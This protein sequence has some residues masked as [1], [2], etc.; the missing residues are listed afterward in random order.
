M[1]VKLSVRT[2]FLLRIA[3]L[4]VLREIRMRRGRRTIV[5]VCLLIGGLA[6]GFIG[7]VSEEA[8]AY[9][10]HGQI[11]ILSD[12]D[13]TPA[14]GVISGNGTEIDPY[15]IA[16][17]EIDAEGGDGIKISQTTSHFI[18]RDCFLYHGDSRFTL[19]IW[20][21]NVL[22]GRIQ[23]VTL[24]EM[25]RA[26][27]LTGS[28]NNTISNSHLYQNRHGV[29]LSGSDNNMIENNNVSS[30]R[31]GIYLGNSENNRIVGSIVYDNLYGVEIALAD[32]RGN[33]VT[34]NDILSNGVSL[35]G[36]GVLMSGSGANSIHHNNMSFNDPQAS[37]DTSLNVWDDGYPSGGNCWT[38]DGGVD[39]YSGPNQDQPG[40][41][42]I[43]DSP[44]VIDADS[45]DMYPMNIPSQGCG[46]EWNATSLTPHDPIHIQGDTEFTPENGVIGGSG[47]STDPYIIEGWHIEVTS[48]SGDGINI[49]YTDEYYVIRRVL[50]HGDGTS[51]FGISLVYTY[52]GRADQVTIIGNNIGIS[53]YRAFL[54]VYNSNISS[55]I[56]DGI[57]VYEGDIWLENSTISFNGGN[58]YSLDWEWYKTV[59]TTSSITHNGGS[60][61]VLRTNDAL[62]TDSNISFNAQDGIVPDSR[63]DPVIARNVIIQNGRYG[64]R[65]PPLSSQNEVENNTISYNDVGIF[66]EGELNLIAYNTLLNNRI[67]LFSFSFGSFERPNTLLNNIIESADA[68]ILLSSAGHNILSGNV[69]TGRG[70]AVSHSYLEIVRIDGQYVYVPTHDIDSSNTV[71]GKPVYYLKNYTGGSVPSDGGQVFLVNSTGV[72]VENQNISNVY[73]GIVLAYSSFNEIQN[74]TLQD[75]SIGL[76]IVSSDDNIIYHNAFFNNTIQAKDNIGTNQWDN[77]YPSGGN[78]WSDY[79][80]VDN[81]SGP[82]QDICPDPDGIGDVPYTMSGG[83]EDRYPLMSSDGI[84]DVKPP[85]PE[86]QVNGPRTMGNVTINRMRSKDGEGGI[87]AVRWPETL[88]SQFSDIQALRSQPEPLKTDEIEKL[89]IS[90]TQ[91]KFQYPNVHSA[92]RN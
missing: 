59:I 75:N 16:G 19:G 83:S 79:T 27:A 88:R 39:G 47:K 50:V 49:S 43:S 90:I 73:T 80:G 30:G 15:I 52:S 74:N 57:R 10:P 78:F 92:K 84:R 5:V 24:T 86:G 64:I 25:G 77:G 35:E 45:K 70:I 3:D 31:W 56:G 11:R 71:H 55:N 69:M 42:G 63:G 22:N 26:I 51:R 41:D 72:T 9:T 8:S 7:M 46:I 28:H 36:G 81:C 37:D 33:I 2:Q 34:H 58:G 62:I 23:G 54:R 44:Y 12:S 60:G 85:I 76:E 4:I 20:L 91:N 82:N 17:W 67:G 53:A 32:S 89:E 48:T 65:F 29:Y 18:I 13:F 68:D 21:T 1:I 40:E 61:V 38:D 14:N 87:Y 6:S 66:N